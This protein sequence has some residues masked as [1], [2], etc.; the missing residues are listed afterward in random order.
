MTWL[1]K[2]RNSDRPEFG[3]RPGPDCQFGSAVG[4]VDEW[5]EQPREFE[6]LLSFRQLG[7]SLR[8]IATAAVLTLVFTGSAAAESPVL[9][10]DEAVDTSRWIVRVDPDTFDVGQAIPGQSSRLIAQSEAGSVVELIPGVWAVDAATGR[11]LVGS[12]GVFGSAPET[13]FRATAIPDDPCFSGCPPFGDQWHHEVMNSAAAWD[14][15]TG[16]A[17]FTVAVLDSGINDNHVELSGVVRRSPGCGLSTAQPGSLDHGTFVAGLIGARTDNTFGISGTAWSVDILDVRVLIGGTGSESD[18]IAGVACAADLGADVI[19]LSVVQC[20]PSAGPCQPSQS[21]AFADVIS[22]AAD[23]GAVV[24]ASAGN[25]GTQTRQ[26]PAAYPGVIGVV[27]TN[28]SG[29]VAGF[30]DRGVWADLAAPGDSMVSLDGSSNVATDSGSGTS[31]AS[32][33]VAGAAAVVS[34]AHPTMDSD[35]LL[36]RILWT[37]H[38]YGSTGTSEFGELDLLGA[39]SAP[40]KSVWMAT[41]TGDVIALG[42]APHRGDMSNAVLNQP[43]VGMAATPS[44]GGYWLVAAD[45]GIFT[46]GDAPYLGSTGALV[47]NQPIIGMQRGIGGYGLVAADGGT[48]NFFEPYLGSGANRAHT[49]TVV[50]VIG[51]HQ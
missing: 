14:V 24:V 3:D 10:A 28:E 21:P 47:L 26:Y 9:V 42:D 12:A 23:R 19:N 8:W 5:V 11:A 46:F 2:R 25:T 39:V 50:A 31:F 30:S 32:P 17:A 22:Y 43:I 6:P 1:L 16:N 41:D 27:A 29:N 49:G 44:G 37:T 51:M 40:I 20:E 18:V 34:G 45:G 15:S 13:E 38:S 4:N 48:F 36:R 35:Q 7:S 33:L